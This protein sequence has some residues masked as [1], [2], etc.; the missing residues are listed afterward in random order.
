M[1]GSPSV[2]TPL[3]PLMDA[4]PSN[5]SGGVYEDWLLIWSVVVT[6]PLPGGSEPGLV[7]RLAVTGVPIRIEP[8]ATAPGIG[9]PDASVTVTVIASWPRAKPVVSK[10]PRS[11]VESVVRTLSVV[12]TGCERKSVAPV[13]SVMV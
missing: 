10:L 11:T 3:A 2:A 13:E 6:V 1:R 9:L 8:V 4:A 7:E 12:E 5:P